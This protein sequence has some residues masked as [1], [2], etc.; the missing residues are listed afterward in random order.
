MAPDKP[1]FVYYAPGATHAPHHP[2]KEWVE[3]YKG[4]FD[5]GWNKVRE[6]TL[7]RQKQL[8]IFPATADLTT[9]SP[10]IPAWDSLNKDQ[11]KLYERMMEI[12]AG[13]LEQTDYN[14]GRVV[15]AIRELNQL[16]NTLVIY[17]VGNNG[18]SGEGGLQG[19]L[20]E[21]A[22]FNHVPE[23]YE[24]VLAH[25][26]DLGTWK[27]YNHYPVGWANAMDAPFQW[28]KQVASHYGGTAN[29]LVVSWSA[30]IKNT[31]QMRT[32]WHHV[33]DIVPTIYEAAGVPVPSSVNGVDQKPIEGGV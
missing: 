29:G 11:K 20:N 24:Q 33:I 4:K 30:R 7:A 10:G 13:Y 6:E 5:Q 25:I 28:V 26:Y 32:Q 18:A 31:G 19:A 27:S 22:F 12:Y 3:K 23:D 14:V 16:D 2:R 1:F 9:R 17:I 21:M 15:D 8:G